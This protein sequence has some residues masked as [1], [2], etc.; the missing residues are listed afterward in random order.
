MGI[1]HE[2]RELPVIHDIQT[3]CTPCS[4]SL[5]RSPLQSIPPLHRFYAAF[6][7]AIAS[8]IH[9]IQSSRKQEPA[10]THLFNSSSGWRITSKN[11]NQ[12]KKISWK[13]YI[14]SVTRTFS[15]NKKKKKKSWKIS[16]VQP[17]FYFQFALNLFD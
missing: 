17:Q 12:K 9:T 14:V 16:N 8:T 3:T 6:V 2:M 7:M 4:F 15:L 13:S 5:T 11:H 10:R 1:K